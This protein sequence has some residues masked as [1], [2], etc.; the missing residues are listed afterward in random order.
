MPQKNNWQSLFGA[1]RRATD[2][3]SLAAM[4]REIAQAERRRGQVR[5]RESGALR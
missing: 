1:K 3:A 4:E 2:R 5:Q